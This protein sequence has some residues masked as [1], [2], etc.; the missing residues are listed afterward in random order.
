M[1]FAQFFVKKV[2]TK[3][4]H[5]AKFPISPLKF[6]EKKITLTVCQILAYD[7]SY[8]K[9]TTPIYK[10]WGEIFIIKREPIKMRMIRF[11]LKLQLQAKI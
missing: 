8:S 10:Q 4:S 1:R 11:C 7:F 6:Q 2:L 3:N 9:Q 5:T